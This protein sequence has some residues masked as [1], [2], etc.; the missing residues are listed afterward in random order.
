MVQ[1]SVRSLVA[2]VAACSMVGCSLFGPR[3]QTIAVSSDPMGASV[4]MNGER[5]GNAPVRHQVRRGED[6]LIEVRK[7]GYETQFRNPSRSLSGLGI[8]DVV[9]G[10]IIL[11]PFF[12][13]LS[14]AAWEHEPSTFGVILT[15]EKEIEQ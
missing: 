2:L 11:V 4:I 8:L 1:R 10:A 3:M 12:G 7:R 14:S 9:G 13:L 5:V 6:L 15:P